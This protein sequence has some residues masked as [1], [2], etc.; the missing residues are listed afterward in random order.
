MIFSHQFR[1]MAQ[2]G[3][4]ASISLLGGF[5]A[6]AKLDYDKPG[7]VYSTLF[8]LATGLERLMKIAFILEHKATNDLTDPSD[9]QLRT[10]GH[11]ITDIYVVLQSS[12]RTRSITD[13]WF[14]APTKQGQLLAAL[15][16]FSCTSRY[17]NIDQVVGGRDSPDPLTRWFSV[18]MQ[19]ASDCISNNRLN[20][21]MQRARTYCEERGMFGWEM[22]PTGQWDLTIDVTYQLEIARIS[23]GLCVWT[24]IEVLKPIY[25]LIDRLTREVH[26]LEQQKAIAAPTVPYM[27]E[28]F[29]FCLADKRTAIRRKAWTKLFH[30]AGRV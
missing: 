11:S 30:I 27:T 4:L 3:H 17:Y 6:L 20:E 1:M 26:Q 5:E 15:A 23:R 28:F 9:A 7:T 12:A 16:D 2:E 19:I 8:Q 10:L 25:C 22:G 21:I 18:H 14:E 13:G 29:P 24:I